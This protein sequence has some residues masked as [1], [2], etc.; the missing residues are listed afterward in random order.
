MSGSRSGFNLFTD[1]LLLILNPELG[2]RGGW[3][4]LRRTPLFPSS[5]W[6][7]FIER[8]SHFPTICIHPFR[9]MRAKKKK[10][11]KK[12]KIP[13]IFLQGLMKGM[14]VQLCDA[15]K[16]GFRNPSN[17]FAK[18][19]D[20]VRILLCSCIGRQ[21]ARSAYFPQALQPV[22]EA[23]E[24]LRNSQRCRATARFFLQKIT[25]WVY[26]SQTR[27]TSMCMWMSVENVSAVG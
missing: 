5:S 24:L 18:L 22:M 21:P 19:S 15:I 11:R 4:N 25:I 26:S 10:R 17:M 23:R 3:G 14:C 2:K 8:W 9:P 1:F 7:Y 12:L 13:T 16:S 20:R 6:T 27:D